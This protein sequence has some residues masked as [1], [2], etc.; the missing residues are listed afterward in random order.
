MK[1]LGSLLFALAIGLSA[2]IAVAATTPAKPVAPLPGDSF[3]RLE[4]SF[5]DQDGRPFTLAQRRG[6]PQLV[7]MFY[8][9]C[10]YAC[11]LLI[12]SGKG[13]DHALTPVERAGLRVLY[14][15]FDPVRDQPKVLAALAAKRN[16]DRTRWTLARTDPAGVRRTAAVLGVRY[17]QLANGEFNHSSMLI[18][19][20][21]EGRVV[22]RTEK[23]GGVPDPEFLKQVRQAI[24]KR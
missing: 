15:S 18:L 9:S 6:R 4:D 11:P 17:R 23:L 1:T 24:A 19:L 20:D 16:L 21:R 10:K 12:D 14:I 13:V 2:G 5:V 7:A 3:L 22:A 8:S